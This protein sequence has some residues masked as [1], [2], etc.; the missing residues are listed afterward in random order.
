LLCAVGVFL[1]AFYGSTCLGRYAGA[2]EACQTL[3]AAVIDVVTC[4]AGTVNEPHAE[5]R[6]YVIE[7]WRAANV[8]VAGSRSLSNSRLPPSR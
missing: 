6:A 7:A 1:L 2:Y 3:K 4:A 5:N 8:R